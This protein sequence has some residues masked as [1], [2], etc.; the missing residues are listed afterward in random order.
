MQLDGS[1]VAGS[2]T[3]TQGDRI[4]RERASPRTIGATDPPPCFGIKAGNPVIVLAK[5]EE[6]NSLKTED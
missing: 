2:A 3:L 1:L 6:D 4:V 5:K